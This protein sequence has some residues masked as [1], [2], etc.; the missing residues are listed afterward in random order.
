METGRQGARGGRVH[1]CKILKGNFIF[2]GGGF[3][4]GGGHGAGESVGALSSII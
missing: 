2:E 3:S 1:G 4:G